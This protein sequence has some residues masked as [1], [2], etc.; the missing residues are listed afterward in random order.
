MVLKIFAFTLFKSYIFFILQTTCPCIHY[1]HVK[2]SSVKISHGHKLA[3]INVSLSYFLHVKVTLFVQCTFFY[4][5]R[6]K[7]WS[8]L[9]AW[10]DQS[11]GF[12]V[13][14]F[15]QHC[16]CIP[17][18]YNGSFRKLIYILPFILAAIISLS[19][20]HSWFLNQN[21]SLSWELISMYHCNEI[22]NLAL[23]LFWIKLNWIEII[24]LIKCLNVMYFQKICYFEQ[25]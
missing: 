23:M 22:R 13:T 15:I 4:Q 6:R 2:P 11:V 18:V 25:F 12:E 8:R 10:V 16:R 21:V 5:N 19:I 24:M 3:E 14:Q 7:A 20:Q 17:I 1:M 9:V